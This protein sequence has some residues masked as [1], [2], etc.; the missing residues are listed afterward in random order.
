MKPIT[1]L[2]Q[3]YQ[4]ALDHLNEVYVLR[5]IAMMQIEERTKTAEAK[6]EAANIT[7]FKALGVE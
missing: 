5:R 2:Y 6:Y 7:Y 3:D 4:N 1:E